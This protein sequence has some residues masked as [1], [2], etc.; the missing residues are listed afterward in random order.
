M[1]GKSYLI[2]TNIFLEILLNQQNADDCENF[3]NRI[4]K[5]KNS[6]YISSFTLHSIEVIMTR[7]KQELALN[8]FLLFIEKSRIIR[9][10]T[11]TSDEINVLKI[12]QDLKLDFDD[13][14]Q[15]LLCNK[16]NLEIISYD[17]HFDKTLIKRFEPSSLK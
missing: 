5:N 14:I 11:S 1:N 8:D 12:M 6:F 13:S 15:V 10:E 17:K 7:N 16:L 2:D 9:V 4:R 3:L